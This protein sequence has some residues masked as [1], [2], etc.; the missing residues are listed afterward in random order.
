[1]TPIVTARALL[2]VRPEALRG[3][4]R[5]QVLFNLPKGASFRVDVGPTHRLIRQEPEKAPGVS[6]ARQSFEAAAQDRFV[7]TA[8]TG[9]PRFYGVIVEGSE[10]GV[11]LDTLGINGARAETA[12]A[13]ARDAYIAEVAQ[14]H[15]DL[16]VVAYGTNEA[17]DGL[18]VTAYRDQFHELV[19]RLRAGAPDADCLIV[20]PPDAMGTAAVSEPRV[21]QITSIQ[22]ESAHELGCGFVSAAELMG[23]E[24][25]FLRWVHDRP[26]LARSDRI[27][28]TINGY[29]KLGELMSQQLLTDYERYRAAP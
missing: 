26:Q 18:R 2:D 25:S 9:M 29:V 20:G 13:W 14:R 1:V 21:Q 5:W 12:I 4:A 7:L 19:G 15:P 6:I 23:G 8:L 24:G 3:V 17:F 22:R 11:V 16:V 10:P 27:H 28:L